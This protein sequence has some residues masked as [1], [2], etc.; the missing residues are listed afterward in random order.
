M[1]SL[2]QFGGKSDDEFNAT[3]IVVTGAISMVVSFVRTCL[4]RILAV[5]CTNSQFLV[6]ARSPVVCGRLQKPADRAS[7][8]IVASGHGRRLVS[9]A[10]TDEAMKSS[11]M[12]DKTK[13]FE[14]LGCSVESAAH[15]AS[16]GLTIPTTVQVSTIP[17]LLGGLRRQVEFAMAIRQFRAEN[18]LLAPLPTDE[19]TDPA[20]LT[21]SVELD[22]PSETPLT[23]STESVELNELSETASPLEMDM[24]TMFPSPPLNDTDDV[25]M[26]GAE[27]GSG[28]T[29]AYLLPYIE[30]C[31]EYPDFPA[32]A[33]IMVPSRELCAQVARQLGTYFPNAPTH[34]VLAGGMPPD[35][36]DIRAV[37]IVIATPAA[38]L[39]YFRFSTQPDCNDKF[40]VVDEADMLLSGS[41][42][43][44]VGDVLNQPGMKPF[45]TRKN[46]NE[47]AINRNRLVFVGATYPH[48]AGDRVKSIVT[49]MKKRYPTIQT[50]Q[51]EDIH[52]RSS[53]ISESWHYLPTE[54]ERFKELSRILN[55]DCSSTDKVMVFCRQVDSAVELHTSIS[56]RLGSSVV[57][58][59][60]DV[61]QL[62]KNVSSMDRSDA[63]AQFRN[64]DSRLLVCTDIAARGLDLGSVS[65]VVEYEFSGNVVGYLHRIGRTARAGG[66]GITNH[67]FD[68]TTRPLADAIQQRSKG[69]E[70]VVEGIF[71]RDRSFRRKLRKRQQEDL[72]REAGR[73]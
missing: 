15:L 5:G 53:R 47:R 23:E 69:N 3:H 50:L 37:R 54:E 17:V 6:G 30:V 60:G 67:F 51:T 16:L 57:E 24:G 26:I 8:Q 10:V 41:F 39:N 52:K 66:S 63:L 28:K 33:I 46:Q 70:A 1:I 31:K 42:L 11:P 2:D 64:G 14:E 4:V 35:V 19:G 20:P 18:E 59:F 68:D 71:S 43:K 62:H 25:L 65:R 34:L 21:E 72:D 58:K 9:S 56:E 61:I 22:E 13:T 48:W 55:E 29:L 49:W 40:I 38:L 44:Q 45:A 73:L 32:K 12:F 27:T 36:S 7:Y